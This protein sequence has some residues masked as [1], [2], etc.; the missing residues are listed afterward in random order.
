[1]VPLAF[2][3][4]HLLFANWPV[5]A[6]AL[7]AHLPDALSV[8]EH[9]GTG[10]LSVIPFVNVHTRPRGLPK[11]VGV[12]VPELN[13]RTYVTC[14][15]EPGVYFFSLDA[16]SALAVLGARA[17]HFLPY[18]YAHSRLRVDDGRVT[19]E[20]RRRQP[21]DRPAR[22]AASYRP[23]GDPFEADPGSLAAFLAERR[24]LYTQSPSGA[25]R[26]TD[27]THPRW[28]LYRAEVSVE[29]NGLFEANGFAHPDADPTL[30][31]SPG[32]DVVT[33]RSKRW[34]G[35]AGRDDAPPATDA[36]SHTA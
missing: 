34:A 19:F 29:A 30:Y 21:G 1:M 24:R 36:G 28:P 10:W 27:V 33:T 13:V 9:D 8:Q 31:Y 5:D 11:W 17:T 22:Y 4:R 35:G 15:G 18:Y 6:D 7:A 32:V 12:R 26:Y 2:G 20:S 3:W 16:G 25:V 23:A 14:D